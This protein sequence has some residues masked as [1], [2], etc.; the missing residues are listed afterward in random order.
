MQYEYKAKVIS[1]YDGDTIT[2]DIDLGF[3][4]T[5]KSQK[6]RLW[7]INAPEVRG[8]EKE[9]GYVSKEHLLKRILNKEV[10]LQTFKDK[11]GKY[12]RWLAVVYLD[13]IDINR[14]LIDEGLA[15]INKYD[16]KNKT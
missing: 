12:G 15:V 6:I 3:F 10:L 9:R 11:K 5:L 2:V 13:G 16:G 14:E 4:T 8:D 1:V 7:G